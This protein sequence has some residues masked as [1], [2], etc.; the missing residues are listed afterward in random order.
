MKAISQTYPLRL[1][2]IILWGNAHRNEQQIAI[3]L[4]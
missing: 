2:A 3:L 1:L 4:V